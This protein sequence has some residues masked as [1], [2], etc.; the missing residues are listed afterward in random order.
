MHSLPYLI[1]MQLTAHML[2]AKAFTYLLRHE[3]CACLRFAKAAEQRKASSLFVSRT[4]NWKLEV[5]NAANIES[6]PI[7]IYMYI[8]QNITQ[9]MICS[10]F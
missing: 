8:C 10:I 1:I 4:A 5:K 6:Q 2:C 9:K 7:F 3:V